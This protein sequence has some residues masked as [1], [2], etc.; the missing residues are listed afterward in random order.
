MRARPATIGVASPMKRP[1]LPTVLTWAGLLVSLLFTYLA[2]RGIDFGALRRA[3]LESEYWM[4]GPALLLLAIAILLRAVRWRILFSPGARPPLG[5]VTNALMVGYFFNTVLPARAGE[6]ARVLALRQRAGTPRFE[7]LGTVVAER[8]L[9]VLALLILLFAVARS[10][11][12]AAW[13][14]SALVLGAIMFVAIAVAFVAFALYGERPAR[15]LLRPLALFPRM[16]KE[17]RDL[18]A[19]NLVLGF[20]VFRRPS[21]AVP[22]FGLTFFSWLLIAVAFWLCTDGFDLGVGFAAGIFVVVAVNLALIVPSGPAGIGVFE[23]ATLVALLP[24]DVDRSS[25]LSYA[26][27][28]HALNSIP[29]I[30]FG[31]IALH[32]HTVAVR[33]QRPHVSAAELGGRPDERAAPLP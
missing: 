23:A 30:A 24:Y 12:D 11:P 21:I 3:L 22:A 5:I 2:F 7:G 8:A 18:A 31:Y 16:S 9:D 13:L 15:V 4:L 19:A 10:L 1:T 27:V 20:A 17:R 32:Y 29:F 6:A 14:P 26:L 33:R 28:L 25:A